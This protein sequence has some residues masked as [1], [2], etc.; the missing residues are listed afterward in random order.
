MTHK[1]KAPF[2]IDNYTE[3]H[4]EIW[5]ADNY[6]LC[7]IKNANLIN[8]STFKKFILLRLNSHDKL[9]EALTFLRQHALYAVSHI[10]HVNEIA[11]DNRK[12]DECFID[13]KIPAELSIAITKAEQALKD[14]GEI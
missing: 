10:N 3:H 4:S 14:A 1:P 13:G 7:T 12:E 2:T 6:S 8:V 9:L 11:N 5:D